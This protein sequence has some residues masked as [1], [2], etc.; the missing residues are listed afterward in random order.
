V[1]EKVPPPDPPSDDPYNLSWSTDPR[2]R[3]RGPARGARA[4]EGEDAGGEDDDV[5][6]V[7]QQGRVGARVPMDRGPASSN[8][9]LVVS[10]PVGRGCNKC[11]ILAEMKIG[12]GVFREG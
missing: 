4:F 8:R 3:P 11:S 6:P 10:R 12:G 2:F 1:G 7:V 5:G 9:D